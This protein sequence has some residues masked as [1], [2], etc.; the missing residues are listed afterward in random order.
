MND[1]IVVCPSCGTKNRIPVEKKSL[2]PK[3]GR[4]GH[5]LQL[6]AGGKVVELDDAGFNEFVNRSTVPVMVDFYSPTC[7]PCRALAP[8]VETLARQYA[9][10]INIGKLDTSRHQLTAG[11]FRIRGVPTMIFFRNG[12]VVDQLVGAAPQSQIEQILNTLL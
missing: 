12:Q 6:H 7:G 2:Q 4:C 10:R 9:G 5:R 3:C 8:V 1:M 11:R